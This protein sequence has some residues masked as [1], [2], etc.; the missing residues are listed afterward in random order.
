MTQSSKPNIVLILADNLGWG[1]LGCY[2]GGSLRGAAT[3][4]IDELASQGLRLTNFN[5]ESDCVP[6]RA[7][8]MTGR[9]AIRTGAFQSL[10]QGVPQG[11]TR[12][13]VLLPELLK[14]QGYKTAHFGKW[15]LGDIQSRLPSA[16]GFDEWYGLPRTLNEAYF[17]T[18]V[19]YDAS[20]TPR[21]YLMEGK[22][23]EDSINLGEFNM[24]TRRLI[25]AEIVERSKTFM[26]EQV[27]NDEPFFLY[28]PITQMHFP[29]LAHPDFVGKTGYGEMADSL[30]EMDH[31]VGQLMDEVEALGIRDNTLFI[32]ASDNG[33]EFRDPWRG[34]AGYW[35]GTYHT[36]M[37]GGLRAPAIFA[38]PNKIEAGRVSDEVIHVTDLYTTLATLAGAADD[39]PTDRPVDGMNQTEFLLGGD[40]T[41]SARDGFVYF[42]KE[43]LRA[44][45]WREWKCHYFWEPEVNE[46][47]GKLESPMLFHLIQDPKE[48]TNIAIAN[49]W[50]FTPITKMVHAFKQSLKDYPAIPPGAPDPYIPPNSSTYERHY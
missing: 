13:E 18:S 23:G 40:D 39:I 12:W 45:K 24:D 43:D 5:V 47:K 34:T 20:Q 35:R 8:L 9:H 17:T 11:L 21:P 27:A 28:A 29:N 37:E 26:R 1:E 15:H 36:A 7:A 32:F 50:V 4:R 46:S 48:E 16:R 14:K 10:P 44:A 22:A 19:G 31:R 30:A 41:K 49:T 3:P 33:P 2:G 6:T 38:W 42:I 25:D